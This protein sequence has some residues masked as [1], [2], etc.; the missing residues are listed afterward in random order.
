MHSY[1]Q[2]EE[3][4]YFIAGRLN[5]EVFYKFPL[6]YPPSLVQSQVSFVHLPDGDP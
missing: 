5:C 6:Y 3:G 4:Y 2:K 1:L